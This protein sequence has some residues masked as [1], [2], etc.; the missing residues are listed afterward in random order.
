M[1]EKKKFVDIEV[2]LLKTSIEALGTN[3]SLNNKTIKLDLSRKLRGKGLNATFQIMKFNDNLIAVPKRMELLTSYV[4]KIVRKKIDYV[5][6]SF[7]VVTK[8]GITVNIK[9]LLI[10]RKKVSRAVR[11]RL[12]EIA[13]ENIVE[14]VKNNDYLDIVESLFNSEFQKSILPKLKKIYPLAFCDLRVW[15]A[16]NISKVDLGKIDISEN[17]ESMDDIVEENTTDV[18]IN[19]EEDDYAQ[20]E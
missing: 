11:K 5:E 17:E 1:A 20:Q 18:V 15:D 19:D 3:S 14:Y 9:P 10:T 6:D 2:P 8:D 13:K 7:I 16:K 4:V 12:R